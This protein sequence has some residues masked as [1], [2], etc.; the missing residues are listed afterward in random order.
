MGI[1]SV[2]PMALHMAARKARDDS[3]RSPNLDEDPTAGLATAPAAVAV[4]RDTTRRIDLLSRL[5]HNN[6]DQWVADQLKAL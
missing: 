4:F 5:E 6:Q 3:V 1:V 2:L